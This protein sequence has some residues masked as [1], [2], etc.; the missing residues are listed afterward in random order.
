MGLSSFNFLWY[1]PKDASFLEQN[2]YRPF[3][4]IQ[5]RWFCTNWK[6]V[7]DFLLVINSNFGPILH[8]FCDTATYWLKI[9]NFFLSHSYLTPSLGMKP[10]EFLDELCIAKTRVLGLSL[11]EDFVI[12]ACVVFTQC[13]RVTDGQTDG[14]TTRPYLIQGSAYSKLCW[15]PVIK[16]A[17]G[18][19][20]KIPYITY[21]LDFSYFE[22]YKKIT[23]FCNLFME[24]PSYNHNHNHNHECYMPCLHQWRPT[25]HYNVDNCRNKW[26]LRALRKAGAEWRFV[27]WSDLVPNTW[28][29]DWE[30]VLPELGPRP[31]NKS[32]VSSGGTELATS[33]FC[34]VEQIIPHRM[35]IYAY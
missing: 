7:C 31:H 20:N 32:C 10:F 12:L 35:R 28:T 30:G 9:V 3:K 33:W 8:C 5:G 18:T 14:R 6:G 15:C 29:T 11:G 34:G 17:A 1:G 24:R 27:M 22:N 4:V 19:Q 16:L 2:A 21:I 23:P 13:Q 26:V 25:V